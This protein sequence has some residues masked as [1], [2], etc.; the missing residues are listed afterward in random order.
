MSSKNS[1]F[2]IGNILINKEK[3]QNEFSL[4]ILIPIKYSQTFKKRL[5]RPSFSPL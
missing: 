2:Y 1:T 3:K 5:I 4:S